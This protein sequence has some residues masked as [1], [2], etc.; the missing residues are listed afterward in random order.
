MDL[1]RVDKAIAVQSSSIDLGDTFRELAKQ[2]ILRTVIKYFGQLNTASVHVS[3]EGSMFRCTVNIHMSALKMM[4]AEFQHDDC[5]LAFKKAL[6]K[7]ESQLR[8]A[9]QELRENKASRLDKEILL[10]DGLRSP[11]MM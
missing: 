8:R 1:Q 11:S 7:V 3:R 10:R 9:K 5:Y 2:S 6:E 4:S